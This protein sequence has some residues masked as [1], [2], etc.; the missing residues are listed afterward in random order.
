MGWDLL[1]WSFSVIR[2][3]KQLILFPLFS[4]AAALAALFLCSLARTGPA[5]GLLHHV[6]PAD[7]AWAAPAYF[8]V[9]FVIVFF[10]CALAACAQAHFSGEEPTLSYGFRQAA[11][12]L[13]PILGWALLSTTVGLIL[14]VIERRA[15]WAGKLAIWIFG[16][17]WGMATYLVVPVL[18]SEDKGTV[19]SVRRS[20]AL[21]R[22]TWSDQ[23]VAEIR[24]GWRSLLFF[25]PTLILGA[26][27]AN[28]YPFLLPFAVATFILGAA[29]LS[30]A[31]GVFEVAL[32][33]YAA[34]NEV[35]ADWSSDLSLFQR[36][37]PMNT[38]TLDI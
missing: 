26:I 28:G 20:A 15:S 34:L 35:P 6:G 19:E 17:A 38:R 24:L 32:Y 12:H 36:P 33:R 8:L 37:N 5:D 13:A 21:V 22:D 25:V 31:K 16:F 2:K 30:A 4:G 14:Q 3:H 10:N 29:A 7:L 27:G 18:I 11:S 9:S 1:G 23:L